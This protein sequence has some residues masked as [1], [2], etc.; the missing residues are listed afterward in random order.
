MK[1]KTGPLDFDFNTD[2]ITSAIKSLKLNKANFG[3]VTN[4]ILRCNPNAIALPL[5][6]MFNFILRCKTFPE[7]WNLPL[8]KPIHKS[9]SLSKPDNYR[10]ICISSHLSKQFT[11][12]LRKRLEKWTAVSNILPNKSS[13]FRKGLRTED[14]IFILTTVLDKYAKRDKKS[15]HVLLISLNSMIQSITIFHC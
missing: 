13:G 2:D 5:C 3:I 12:L 1:N 4:E 8:I 9:G 7:A 14:G 6:S 15:I 10:G 11:V